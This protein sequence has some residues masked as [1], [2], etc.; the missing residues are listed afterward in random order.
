MQGTIQQPAGST[1]QRRSP[2]QVAITSQLVPRQPCTCVA[3]DL[4]LPLP[5]NKKSAGDLHQG[6]DSIHL[7]NHPPIAGQAASSMPPSGSVILTGL[8]ND[9]HRCPTGTPSTRLTYQL[10]PCPDSAGAPGFL[11]LGFGLM[12]YPALPA[13]R[14]AEPLAKLFPTRE[15][16]DI[17]P[18]ESDGCAL[19]LP[20]SSAAAAFSLLSCITAI[21]SSVPCLTCSA[22]SNA[23]N[24][25]HLRS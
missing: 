3:P 16:R 25:R 12:G 1:H 13:R 15:A 4:S 14:S 6:N 11:S 8:W 17:W 2:F 5:G 24:A 23:M 18:P 21:I 20:A 10:R 7:S 22:V 19:T 9:D